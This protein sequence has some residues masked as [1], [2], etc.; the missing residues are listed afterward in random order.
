VGANF[1]ESTGKLHLYR[2]QLATKKLNN[3]YS[4]FLVLTPYLS[5]ACIE[6]TEDKLPEKE[7][8]TE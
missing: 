7:E 8:N 6:E 3:S 5:H 1:G 2:P 4:S